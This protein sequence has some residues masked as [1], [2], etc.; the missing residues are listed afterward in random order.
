[1]LRPNTVAAAAGLGV[2]GSRPVSSTQNQTDRTRSAHAALVR[3]APLSNGA[4]L[5]NRTGHWARKPDLSVV[6]YPFTTDAADQDRAC[7]AL[8]L[9]TVRPGRHDFPQVR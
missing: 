3:G 9:P 8:R 4:A 6:A 7:G 2:S 5:R 1:M